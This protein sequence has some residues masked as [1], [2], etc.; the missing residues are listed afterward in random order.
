MQLAWDC[1]ASMYMLLA[2]IHVQY[3]CAETL[4]L[5][6]EGSW[7][8]CGVAACPATVLKV[9]STGFLRQHCKSLAHFLGP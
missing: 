5:R 8:D 6:V 1:V 2:A 3:S 9:L 4:F 7:C